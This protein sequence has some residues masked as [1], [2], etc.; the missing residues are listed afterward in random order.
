MTFAEPRLGAWREDDGV[1]FAVRSGAATELWVCLFEKGREVQVPLTRAD[2]GVFRTFIPHLRDGALYGLRADG[3]YAPEVGLW[4]DRQKLL[5]DPYAL[6]IDRRYRPDPRLHLP[7]HLAVDTADL[8]PK[9]RVVSPQAVTPRPARFTPG[10]LIYELNVRGFS[11]QHQDVPA[12]ERGTLSALLNPAV[13]AHLKRLKVSAVELMPITA[14]IDEARL[15]NLGLK[16]AWGYNPITFMALDPGLAP[17]GLAELRR[18]VEGLHDAG[19]GVILDLVFNHTGET[20]VEGPTLSLRGLDNLA[21]YAHPREQPGRL[22]ND[23]G[24]GNTVNC[25]SPEMRALIRASLRHFVQ[26]AGVDGFRFDLAPVLGRTETGFDPGAPLLGD[27]ITDDL[28]A[29]R[30][31]IAE[32]WDCGPGGYQLGRFP[33]PFLEWNDAYRDDVRRFWRGDGGRSGSLATRICG[34]SDIFGGD[35][36]RETRSVNFIAAHDGFTLADLVSYAERHN[37]ANGEDNRDGHAENLSWN[38]G[39]EGPS[40]DPVIQARRQRD[41]KALLA[42]LFCSRGTIMLTA[43]DEFGRSQGGNNNAYAQD[44][45]T[46]WIDWQTRDREIEAYCYQLAEF[47]AAVTRLGDPRFLHEDSEI[48]SVTW[49]D[50]NGALLTPETWPLT[51]GFGLEITFIDGRGLAIQF[52]QAEREVSFKTF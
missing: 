35:G 18:V 1:T 9:A 45:P 12:N 7:A 34:S 50:A 25:Q 46:T 14:W 4:F 44:N 19:I 20:D 17:G 49:R 30:V 27:L 42:T 24:C 48:S 26:F 37:L 41:I 40:S 39:V 33:K 16:N 51:H 8:V 3:P 32:P 6:E 5:V 22:I 11:L 23:T 21:A 15:A 2:D 10:G 28:L 52:D 36:A 29:D 43:G 13:I 47:R 38:Y 31:L